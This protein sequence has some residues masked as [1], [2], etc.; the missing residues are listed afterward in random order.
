MSRSINVFPAKKSLDETTF[1]EGT[2]EADLCYYL[3][4][5]PKVVSYQPQPHCIKYFLNDEKH[6]YTADLL[7][8]YFDGKKRLIEIKYNRDIDRISDF[9]DWRLAIKTACESQGFEFEVLTEDEIRKQPLYENLTLL[10]ASHDKALDK[11]FLVKVINT[12][13]QNDDVL[14]SDLL[15]KV[16]FDSELEQVYKLIFDRKIL[17]PID[18]EFLSTQTSIKHSGES[19]ECY[20]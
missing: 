6:C 18:T 9:D 5:D 2:L 7:V 17:A 13:D 11:G 15:P 8:N 19:Y 14:I 10:W 4:F 1:T 12:L 3:E 20:L 16:N